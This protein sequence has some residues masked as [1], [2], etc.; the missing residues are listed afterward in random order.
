MLDWP[1]ICCGVLSG[2]HGAFDRCWSGLQGPCLMLLEERGNL[3][4]QGAGNCVSW[5]KKNCLI[6]FQSKVYS[7]TL[8][9]VNM[10]QN[11]KKVSQEN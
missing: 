7:A 4:L 6:I 2:I 1:V 9:A 5:R 8:R 3:L 11:R 10:T